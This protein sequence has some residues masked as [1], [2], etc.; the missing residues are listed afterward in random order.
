MHTNF[1][2]AMTLADWLFVGVLDAF[3]FL[4]CYHLG[5]ETGQI[6]S[7]HHRPPP[8]SGQS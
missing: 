3:A 4:Y 2:E 1:L 8:K 6:P 7:S 5:R